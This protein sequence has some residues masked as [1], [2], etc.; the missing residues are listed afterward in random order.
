MDMY[1]IR[2]PSAWANLGELEKAGATS[3]RIGDEEMPDRIRWIRSYVVHEADGR[4]GTVCIY[5]ASDRRIDQGAR[6]PRRHAGRRDPA[7]H[8]HGGHPRR[9]REGGCLTAPVDRVAPTTG[10][11]QD[12]NTHAG[13]PSVGVSALLRSLRGPC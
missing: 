10:R 9:P 8:R 7:D 5:Q 11:D 2:R 4:V 1:A 13:R 12:S 3:A 6:R